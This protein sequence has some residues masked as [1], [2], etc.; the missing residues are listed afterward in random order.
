M[1]HPLSPLII[2][3]LFAWLTVGSAAEP[4]DI[5]ADRASF[6]ERAGVSLFQ[7]DVRLQRGDLSITADK[8][9][10][11]RK[12]GRLERA[13]AEG[14]P[15]RYTQKLPDGET[16]LAE[17]RTIE[18]LTLSEEL[19][20]SG[21]AELRRGRN[22]FTGE[23]IIYHIRADRVEASSNEGGKRRVQAVIYPDETP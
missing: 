23:R 1:F 13:V 4:I 15:A 21:A 20:L 17:A 22:R 3:L 5:E 11:Y 12:T 9:T 14:K 16:I 7:G 2:I 6:D 8:I 10:L 18:Y 19:H